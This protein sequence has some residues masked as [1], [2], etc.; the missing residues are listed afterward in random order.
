MKRSYGFYGADETVAQL[1]RQIPWGHNI[2]IFQKVKEPEKALWYV[3][4]TLENGW[5]PNV[6]A[7]QIDSG[8]TSVSPP[9][10]GSTSTC[11]SIT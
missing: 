5:S 3:R 2:E 8:S 11:S 6:L 10:P 7:L 4:K 9:T 1:V